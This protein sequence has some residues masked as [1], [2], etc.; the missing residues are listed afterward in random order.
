[1]GSSYQFARRNKALRGLA[2]MGEIGL[3]GRAGWVRRTGRDK[4]GT[5]GPTAAGAGLGVVS[6]AI[7]VWRLAGSGG[8]HHFHQRYEGHGVFLK[9]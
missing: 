5:E 4:G 1:M 6:L 3:R 7:E 2:G 9:K 8:Y